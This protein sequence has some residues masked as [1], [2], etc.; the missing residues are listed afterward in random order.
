MRNYQLDSLIFGLLMVLL[1]I[2]L[3]VWLHATH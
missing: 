2:V 3:G 1:I